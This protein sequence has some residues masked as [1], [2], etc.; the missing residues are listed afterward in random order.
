MEEGFIVW[1]SLPEGK[2]PAQIIKEHVLSLGAAMMGQGG[3]VH[4]VTSSSSCLFYT[5]SPLTFIPDAFEAREPF[6]SVFPLKGWSS[7]HLGWCS[8]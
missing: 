5:S 8:G 3:S 6:S 2:C 7:R 1:S 4:T